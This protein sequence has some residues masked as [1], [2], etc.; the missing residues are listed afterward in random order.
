M[1]EQANEVANSDTTVVM[2][3][4]DVKVLRDFTDLFGFVMTDTFKNALDAF[5]KDQTLHNQTV[6]K[7]EICRFLS[8]LDPEKY[9]DLKEDLF[10]RI[11][12]DTSEKG[13]ELEF[14]KTL[15]EQLTV[16]ES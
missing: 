13:Y 1:D 3:I 9:P 12:A 4:E 2:T 15:E 16:K 8:S 6:V 14:N 11:I 7:Y 10:Q 5:E